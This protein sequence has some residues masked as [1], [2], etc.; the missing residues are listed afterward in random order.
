MLAH[1]RF[2]KGGFPMHNEFVL[3][4]GLMLAYAAIQRC[5]L[6]FGLSFVVG[7]YVVH[8]VLE[9]FVEGV[10]LL[11]VTFVCI[12]MFFGGIGVNFSCDLW[13]GAGG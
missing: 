8:G 4:L 13:H 7:E 11:F 10:L 12:A 2:M 5:L 6:Y 3:V 9:S 1:G